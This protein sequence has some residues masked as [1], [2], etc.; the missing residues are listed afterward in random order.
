MPTRHPQGTFCVIPVYGVPIYSLIETP[1][2]HLLS[3]IYSWEIKN[4][5]SQGN[6]LSRDSTPPASAGTVAQSQLLH[7]SQL[8]ATLNVCSTRWSRNCLPLYPSG[9]HP[10][11]S[12]GFCHLDSDQAPDCSLVL[13]PLVPQKSEPIPDQLICLGHPIASLSPVCP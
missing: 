6:N 5:K 7:G 1:R 13:P 11:Y 9:P 8:T 2:V 12:T 3:F 4:L 10:V